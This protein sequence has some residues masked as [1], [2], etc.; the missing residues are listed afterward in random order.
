MLW[1]LSISG[2]VL[3]PQIWFGVEVDDATY[4]SG[5]CEKFYYSQNEAFLGTAWQVPKAGPKIARE[6]GGIRDGLSFSS[7]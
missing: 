7:E 1:P 5:G 4:P 2:L 3:P 6:K